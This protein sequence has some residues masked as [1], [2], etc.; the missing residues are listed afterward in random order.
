M[1][2]K[3]MQF[4]SI[5]LKVERKVSFAT[6]VFL[7]CLV[8]E[9]SFPHSTRPNCLNPVVPSLFICSCLLFSLPVFPFSVLTF[10]CIPNC[11]SACLF[12][13]FPKHH[14]MSS[15]HQEDVWFCSKSLLMAEWG[16]VP[17]SKEAKARSGWLQ[18]KRRVKLL[19]REREN[20]K[21]VMAASAQPSVVCAVGHIWQCYSPAYVQITSYR[22]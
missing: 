19:L 11:V 3:G 5:L 7:V 17:Y 1:M 22:S 16:W 9:C 8:K 15:H 4:I 12:G 18:H 2:G 20:C 14:S 10:H 21:G 13:F 6:W